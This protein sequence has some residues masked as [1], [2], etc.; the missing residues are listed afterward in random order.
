MSEDKS[1]HMDDNLVW[2]VLD[3]IDHLF[4][5]VAEFLQGQGWQV[6]FLIGISVFVAQSVL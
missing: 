4:A 1:E 5:S 2:L 3:V 6:S